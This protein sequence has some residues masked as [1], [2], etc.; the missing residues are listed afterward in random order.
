MSLAA[1]DVGS[2]SIGLDVM[3]DLDGSGEVGTACYAGILGRC[4]ECDFQGSCICGKHANGMSDILL[5]DRSRWGDP[6]L[7]CTNFEPALIALYAVQSML[8]IVVMCRI[9][10][11]AK[12]QVKVARQHGC[13][14]CGHLP[15]CSLSAGLVGAVSAFVFGILKLVDPSRAVGIDP[16]ITL[17]ASLRNIVMTIGN[18]L[19]FMHLVR[20]SLKA[21][22]ASLGRHRVQE[23]VQHNLWS[24][25]KKIA[26]FGAT[27][28]IP[29]IQCVLISMGVATSLRDQMLVATSFYFTELLRGVASSA[30]IFY[31]TRHL[32]RTFESCIDAARASF[33]VAAGGVADLAAVLR[34]SDARVSSSS[35]TLLRPH[36]RAL[37]SEITNL[38]QSAATL[39]KY[40]YRTLK[41]PIIMSCLWF[42]I[43]AIP[44]LWGGQSYFISLQ[45]SISLCAMWALS[46]MYI[47]KKETVVIQGCARVVQS[48]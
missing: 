32:M 6:I 45:T 20:T 44:P 31:D 9:L 34:Q 10:V 17:L 13:S 4:R 22:E 14:K 19:F 48:V 39:R 30:L 18:E 47:P 38:K 21:E 23:A 16:F 12:V 36:L 35:P 42:V 7:V 26:L 40:G 5:L 43:L 27:N 28:T 41:A 29:L 8:A 3:G 33:S 25:R 46:N 1:Q 11:A 2:G 15:L 24:F 37:G